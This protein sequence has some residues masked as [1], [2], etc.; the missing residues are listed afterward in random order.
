MVSAIF[1]FLTAL[2]QLLK[3][4]QSLMTWINQVSGNDPAGFIVKAGIAFDQLN[5]AKTS[6]DKANAAKSISDLISGL[7]PK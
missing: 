4:I 3:M 2:P 1:G 6:E 5:Q 7:P